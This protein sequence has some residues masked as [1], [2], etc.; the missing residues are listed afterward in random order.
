[1]WKRTQVY[2][3]T[4]RWDHGRMTCCWSSLAITLQNVRVCCDRCLK[5]TRP[6]GGTAA[7]LSPYVSVTIMCAVLNNSPAQ[8]TGP[9][10]L[11]WPEWLH[12]GGGVCVF[13]IFF[14]SGITCLQKHQAVLGPRCFL[15]VPTCCICWENTVWAAACQTVATATDRLWIQPPNQSRTNKSCR[16]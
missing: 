9:I 7:N 2:L 6:A 11:S 14:K 16:V 15:L 12:S 8:I 3:V 13:F 1:M 4:G 10:G 5:L